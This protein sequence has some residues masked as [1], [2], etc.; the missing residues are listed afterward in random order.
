MGIAVDVVVLVV[1]VVAVAVVVA[2]VVVEVEYLGRYLIPVEG[3][4]F[5][6]PTGSTAWKLP[7]YTGPCTW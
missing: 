5:P 4:V 7:P 2:E 1:V 3:Q 6:E